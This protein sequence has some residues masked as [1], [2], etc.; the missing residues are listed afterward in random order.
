MIA[1]MTTQPAS[2]E[3]PRY[4]LGRVVGIWAAAAL[5]MGILSWLIAPALTPEITSNPVGA[6]VTR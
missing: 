5:P 6:I 2:T 3:A 1:T 4:T